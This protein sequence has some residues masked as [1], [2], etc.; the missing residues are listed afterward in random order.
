MRRQ[1]TI[2]GILLLACGP[3]TAAPVEAGA[4]WNT[5][6]EEC[7][8]KAD[9]FA[10]KYLWAIGGRLQGRH[11]VLD[12]PLFLGN[13]YVPDHLLEKMQRMLMKVANTPQRFADDCSRCHG[14]VDAFVRQS[15]VIQWNKVRGT[16]SGIAVS[17]FLPSHQGLQADDADFFTR[18]LERFAEQLHGPEPE[19]K[20]KPKPKLDPG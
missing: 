6:C 20:P 10:R 16:E 15:I 1:L 13:H 12:L 4:A 2:I 7:H 9:E 14:E 17:E 19:P 5:R 3:S 11:H 8:G 18:L